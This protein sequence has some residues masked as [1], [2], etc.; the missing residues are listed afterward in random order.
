MR[1]HPGARTNY[2]GVR[3]L[4]SYSAS[5]LTINQ[6]HTHRNRSPEHYVTASRD[7]CNIGHC[8]ADV[9]SE[10]GIPL[11][12]KHLQKAWAAYQI[13]SGLA[14]APERVPEDPKRDVHSLDAMGTV[15]I[16]RVKDMIKVGWTSDPK[17]RFK[18]LKADAVIGYKQG[19][20]RDEFKLQAKC[21]DHLVKGREWFDTSPS[22]M[23]IINKF[24]SRSALSA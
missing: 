7:E 1:K 5:G 2:L 8:Q 22:V 16:V 24:L 14:V 4:K 11:C 19:T 9:N 21:M 6:S 23:L 10:V 17:T 15:Y 3:Q 12:T 20:R 18:D 13:V